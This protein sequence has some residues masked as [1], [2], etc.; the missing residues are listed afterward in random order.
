MRPRKTTSWSKRARTAPSPTSATRKKSTT[1]NLNLNWNTFKRNCSQKAESAVLKESISISRVDI[2]DLMED[3]R[4]SWFRTFQRSGLTSSRKRSSSITKNSI[5]H[6]IRGW[7]SLSCTKITWSSRER[8]PILIDSV[9]RATSTILT[10][11]S[12]MPKSVRP[13]RDCLCPTWRSES[14]ETIASYR[15]AVSGHT[16]RVIVLRDW[17]N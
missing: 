9:A 5:S 15:R 13:N 6:L 11:M 8:S 14:T 7:D 2:T 4:E 17:I 16:I 3:S 10:Q 12:V 1:P